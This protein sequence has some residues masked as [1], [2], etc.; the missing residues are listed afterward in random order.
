MLTG[1][2]ALSYSDAAGV[3][4]AETGRPVQVVDLDVA[5]V[6]ARFRDA[7]LPAPFAEVLAAAEIGLRDGQGERVTTAVQD[8]TGRSPRAFADFVREHAAEWSAG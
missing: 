2:E 7:G 5:G 1:P 8:L 4:A 3:I 6:A